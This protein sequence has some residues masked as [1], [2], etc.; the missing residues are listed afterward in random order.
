M[1]H[2]ILSRLPSVDRFGNLFIMF[3][4]SRLLSVDKSYKPVYHVSFQQTVLCR[5]SNCCELVYD[6][7]S[8]QTVLCTDVSCLQRL[9]AD[10][11]FR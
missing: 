9:K 4:L 10:D 6:L 1:Y 5:W 11:N 7:T 3:H 8:Q 2:T